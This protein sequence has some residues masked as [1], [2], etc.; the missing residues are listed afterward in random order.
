MYD[1]AQNPEFFLGASSPQGFASRFSEISNIKKDWHLYIIKG[2][3][4]SG[5]SGFIHT[6]ATALKDYD[7]NVELI[8]C[9]SDPVSYDGAIFHDLKMAIVDGTYPH[10]VE[11]T[12]LGAYETVISLYDCLDYSSLVKQREQIVELTDLNRSLNERASRFISAGCKLLGDSFRIA[13]EATDSE[14][15]GRYAKRFAARELKRS[16]KE[17][18]P[19]NSNR[20]LSAIT[21][22]GLITFQNTAKCYCEKLY[23]VMDNYGASSRILLNALRSEAIKSGYDTVS[24]YCS[25]SPFEKLDHLFIPEVGI[26]FMTSNKWHKITLEP[27]KKINISRFTDMDYIKK[28][29]QR[30]SFNTKAAKEL[31][32]EAVKLKKEARDTYLNLESH[33][34]D[35][36]DF[37]KVNKKIN[38]FLTTP[39]T[40]PK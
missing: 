27:N 1:N 37:K 3:P 38:K 19:E 35:S 39:I 29:K 2:G 23:V 5:K 18:Q 8:H 28:H 17:T 32:A 25:S 4:G 15:I 20:F 13:L 33:Y 26:G 36:M 7:E 6:V 30:L 16:H 40:Q 12:Y 11:P 31:I 9:A 34:H 24:C 10:I 14:K 21:P 22:D